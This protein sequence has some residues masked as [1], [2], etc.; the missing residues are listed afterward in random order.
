MNVDV[1]K[2]LFL[3]LLVAA[4]ACADRGLAEEAPRDAVAPR[5]D[6][7]APARGSIL[8]SGSSVEV[9]G[10]VSDDTGVAK[11]TINGNIVQVNGDGTFVAVTAAQPGITLLHTVVTDLDGN[12]QSDTRAVL[13]GTLVPVETPVKDAVVV[14]L[15]K[16]A[17]HIAGELAG[18]AL[19]NLDLEPVFKD[20]NPIVDLPVPCLGARVDVERVRK[21]AVKITLVPVDGGLD[22]YAEVGS[23]DVGLKVAYDVGCEKGVAYPSVTATKFALA[24]RFGM[25]T[26]AEGQL[27]LDTSETEAWFEGFRL[28]ST[29]L[30]GEVTDLVE[31]PIGAVLAHLVSEEVQ[32]QVPQLLGGLLTGKDHV[33]DIEAQTVTIAVKPTS[34]YF[35]AAGGRI[36]LDTKVVVH[37]A[38]GSVYP[39]SAAPRP[40]VAHVSGKSIQVGGADDAMNQVLASLWGA[41]IF[42]LTFSV[43]QAGSYAGL[44]VLFDRVEVAPRLPPVVTAL[45]SGGGLRVALGDVE[46]HFIKARPGEPVKTVTRLSVSVETTVTATVRENRVTLVAAEPVVWL[47]VLADGVTGANPFNQES[48]RQLGSFAAKNLVDFVVQMAGEVPIPAVEGMTII[49]AHATTGEA[50]GGYMV[51]TGNVAVR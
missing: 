39:A 11:L 40:T 51:V 33:L 38:P 1:A 6:V 21:G 28:N 5:I 27:A 43:D 15:D 18:R 17:W 16:N 10:T 48:V 34:V 31:E 2:H 49:D 20:M 3:P 8:Q 24:G 25:A 9:R 23:I 26:D 22:V 42:N 29:L 44:G 35:D 47:D 4:G 37:G 30:P 7:R 14:N 41:G 45:P 46:A 19:G 13:G 12:Q 50:A 32:K 36:A